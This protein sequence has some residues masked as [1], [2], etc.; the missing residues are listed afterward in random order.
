[1][2]PAAER[3]CRLP[4]AVIKAGYDELCIR[5]IDNFPWSFDCRM[6]SDSAY[7]ENVISFI[8]EACAERG[9][10]LS[11][12]FPGM[13]DYIRLIRLSGYRRFAR[14]EPGVPGIN[15]DAVGFSQLIETVTEDILSLCP[16]LDSLI[17]R[18]GNR[19]E[20]EY[21]LKSSK[22][23]ESFDVKTRLESENEDYISAEFFLTG[24]K[25]ELNI[26]FS[27]LKTAIEGF[28]VSLYRIRQ[29]LVMSALGN[30]FPAAAGTGIH[31]RFED[32]QLQRTNILELCDNFLT[33]AAGI[34]EPCWLEQYCR[35][36][37]MNA[38]DEILSVE[39]RLRQSGLL[40]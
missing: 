8:S 24:N 11:L 15:T 16:K 1:M 28:A 19:Q 7:P 33:A 26:C 18:T 10:A 35:T 5:I 14:A 20:Q 17:F 27:S 38:D 9:T 40:K 30:Q 23:V 6:K 12:V 21:Y 39:R 3:F 32:L 37:Y 13:Y 34:L 29:Y 36:I 22:V 31:Y 2:P 4:E 25:S